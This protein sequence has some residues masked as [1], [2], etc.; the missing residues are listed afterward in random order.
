MLFQPAAFRRETRPAYRQ[1]PGGRKD[2]SLGLA[3]GVEPEIDA[4]PRKGDRKWLRI[5]IF[6]PCRGSLN[7]TFYPG[8]CA[9]GYCLS[10]PPDF[11]RHILRPSF[12][13]D[14]SW[15]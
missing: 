2:N 4:E 3:P 12:A 11:G 15:S 5:K 10:A 7:A 9:P 14:N 6:R 1:A 13:T 8:A